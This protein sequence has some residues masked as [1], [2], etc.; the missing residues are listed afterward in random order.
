[1]AGFDPCGDSALSTG[2]GP[3]SDTTVSNN[4]FSLSAR[5]VQIVPQKE[6]VFVIENDVVCIR[7]KISLRLAFKDTT[8]NDSQLTYVGLATITR[9]WCIYGGVL[10]VPSVYRPPNG[11]AKC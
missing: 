6:Y 4:V 11:K 9:I 7:E 8:G 1:M 2:F 5:F 10:Q 3:S